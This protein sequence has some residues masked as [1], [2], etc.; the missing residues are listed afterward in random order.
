VDERLAELRRR[1]EQDPSLRPQLLAARVRAGELTRDR[2]ELAAYAGD[3][4]ARL[5]VGVGVVPV[6]IGPHDVSGVAGDWPSVDSA[7]IDHWVRGLRNR[8]EPELVVR[9]AFAAAL[10][11][12]HGPSNLL[13]RIRS[14]LRCPCSR[15]RRRWLREAAASD[16][17]AF[18]PVS[19]EAA[20]PGDSIAY[21]V[22][23]IGE[24]RVRAVVRDALVSWALGGE[25]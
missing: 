8:W 10:A 25:A 21:A 13:R 16:H 14:W 20:L 6:P 1:A 9:A 7:P 24:E 17:M 18:I 22:P 12:N 23:I 15:H 3:P 4:A 11:A 19:P 5:V 2:L